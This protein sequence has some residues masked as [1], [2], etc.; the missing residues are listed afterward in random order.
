MQVA[1]RTVV[2]LEIAVLLARRAT[3][4]P[5]R[6]TALAELAAIPNIEAT[7][8][9]HV[10]RQLRVA[11]LV[12]SRRGADGGWALARPPHTIAVFDVVVALDGPLLAIGGDVPPDGF[13][14]GGAER[15][16]GA[17]R[18]VMRDVLGAVT[19]ADL[20]S[21]TLPASIGELVD[22]GHAGR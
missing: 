9:H 11:G 12:T 17:L 22:V 10:L 1:Q 18:Q 21:G 20:A 2:G 7:F 16:L 13:V 8:V 19:I 5:G 3:D 15:L 14:G 4:R 6:S